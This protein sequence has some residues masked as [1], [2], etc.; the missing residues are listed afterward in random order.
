MI[1]DNRLMSK[2]KAGIVD[3]AIS[4]IHEAFAGFLFMAF[5]IKK[6]LSGFKFMKDILSTKRID[7]KREGLWLSDISKP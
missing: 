6:K 5:E 1:Q 2:G 7:I 3:C 4:I